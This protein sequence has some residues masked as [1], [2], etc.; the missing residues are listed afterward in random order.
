MSTLHLISHTHWDRE[1]YLTF[2]QFRLK[3]VHLIDGLLEILEND[4]DYKYFLLDGQTILLEDYLEIRP[5]REVELTRMIANGR[6]LIGPWYISPDE[7][8][9]SPESHVRNLLEG[10][11]VC[12]KFGGQLR[13]GYLPDTFG[14]IGQMPQ[15]LL[16]FGIDAACVWRGLDHQPLELNWRS[17]DGSELLLSYLRESYSNAANVTPDQ[18]D[19]FIV[20]V[21]ELSR[22]LSP[23][24]ATGQLLVMHGTDH[25]EPSKSLTSAM[26]AYQRKS[27]PDEL[28]HSNF[29]IYFEAVRS[30]IMARGITLPVIA[31]ELR[32]SKHS[33]LLSNVLSTCMWIKQRNQQ[34]ENEL[35]KWVEPLNA[36]SQVIEPSLKVQVPVSSNHPYLAN[37]KYVIQSA[38]KMLMQCHPHDSICGTS[39]DQVHREMEAR[40]DQVDQVSQALVDQNL[41]RICEQIDTQF[42]TV[43]GDSSQAQDILAA[44]VVFNPNDQPQ[45]GMIE[46]NLKL[47]EHYSSVVLLDDQNARVPYHQKGTGLS[48]LISMTMDKKGLKQGLGMVHDGIFAGVAIREFDIEPQGSQAFIRATISS[49]GLVDH[50]KWKIGLEKLES[51]L[52]DENV[53]EFVIHA[54]S[55]PEVGLSFIARDIPPHGYRS[56]WVGGYAESRPAA[57]LPR[58]L[59][60]L[61]NVLLPALKLTTQIPML[62]SLMSRRNHPADHRPARIEN[63]FL[64]IDIARPDGILSITDKRTQRKYIG[65]NRFVD[66]GDCGDLYNYCPP[67]HDQLIRARLTS[68]QH[69]E[70]E[71]SRSLI[72][73]SVLALPKSIA[74]DRKSRSRE[75]KRHE[76]ISTVTLLPG[77]PRVD[78]HVDV[79]NQASDHRLRVH[80]PAPFSCSS[81]Y[82]DGHYEVVERMIGLPAHDAS[83]VEPPRPEVPQRA[84]TFVTDGQASLTIA[85]RGL[86][87]VEVLKSYGG[88]VEIALT[89]LRCVGWLSRDDL[90]TRKGHAGPMGIATPEAQM[91]GRH[92]F[93]YSIIPG[94]SQVLDSIH[95]AYAFEAP[96][97]AMVTSVHPGTL[98]SVMSFIQNS[99]PHFLITAIKSSEGAAGLVVRGFNLQSTPIEVALT[100]FR[101]FKQAWLVNLAEE[102]SEPLP[103]GQDGQV[104]L[105]VTGKKILT[106]RFSD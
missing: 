75:R 23:F 44:I 16:G 70:T 60:S 94:D 93:D 81:A 72:I 77:V 73:H 19:K 5:E 74:D 27:P 4:P 6:I 9:L 71:T 35:I 36:W 53:K 102:P 41:H 79:D 90:A 89:L 68:I 34:C 85:N 104:R 18:P 11:R 12:Q 49:Q 26:Q 59:P 48:E 80:F 3:L 2:Q 92:S 21:S 43:S 30:Q 65:L 63:E 57:G 50:G 66:G 22:T 17:P 91:T 58:K 42:I 29:S 105:H 40:F 37:Q 39:I 20:Q 56:Y 10:K 96:L 62:R 25:M 78:V 32:S 69:L 8:L 31:G 33:P 7:F 76:L 84:F 83:W 54:Y 24:S 87:E 99:N 100:P 52:A 106:I 28:R 103:I 61:V 55:D 67:E 15:I 86:P 1:W 46:T 82:H 101:P 95:L 97:R 38:W 14:H 13:V 64:A 88:N 45:S 51:V 47:D 98:P